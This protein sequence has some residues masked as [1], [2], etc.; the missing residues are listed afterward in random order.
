MT[1]LAEMTALLAAGAGAVLRVTLGASG[2]AELDAA[3]GYDGEIS[4]VL[5]DE[6]G[7]VCG[8]ARRF[9]DPASP[10]RYGPQ[11]G[12]HVQLGGA[13]S[14]RWAGVPVG[15]GAGDSARDAVEA[16]ISD[17]RRQAEARERAAAGFAAFF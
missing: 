6:S 17:L 9:R 3:G 14:R 5:L 15:C 10:R 8:R 1:T 2:V 4:A 7:E 13:G 16:A 11:L 12:W